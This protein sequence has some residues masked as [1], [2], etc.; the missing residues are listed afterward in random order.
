[1]DISTTGYGLQNGNVS[2]RSAQSYLPSQDDS[3]RAGNRRVETVL[4]SGFPDAT[5]VSL[6]SQSTNLLSADQIVSAINESLSSSGLSVNG[7]NPDDYT[8]EAVAD[9]ILSLASDVIA[10]NAGSEDEARE[11]FAQVKT[12]VERGL[13]Q[14]REILDGLGALNGTVASNVDDTEQ[15]LQDGLNSLEARL[16]ELLG[17]PEAT[18]RTDITPERD[19]Q[20]TQSQVTQTAQTSQQLAESEIARERFRTQTAGVR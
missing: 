17:R 4:A 11:I 13:E 8:P 12:G 20:V 6:S 9:R 1:M 18:E 16:T 2:L 14:A 3:D 19:E 5:K 7:V 10:N 15:R